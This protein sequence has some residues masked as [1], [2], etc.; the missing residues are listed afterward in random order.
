MQSLAFYIYGSASLVQALAS[1][2]LIDRYQLL[3][4]PIALG[5]GKP[6]FKDFTKLKLVNTMARPS[7]IVELHYQ[8]NEQ[9][10]AR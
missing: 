5:K 7:G 3:L 10:N 1:H 6:L 9:E 2:N 4:Y 8:P